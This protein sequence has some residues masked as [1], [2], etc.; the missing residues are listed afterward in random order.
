LG[1]FDP[2][3]DVKRSASE[4]PVHDTPQLKDERDA[5]VDLENVIVELLIRLDCKRSSLELRLSIFDL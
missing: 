4:G 5:E 2:L 1:Q 3:E